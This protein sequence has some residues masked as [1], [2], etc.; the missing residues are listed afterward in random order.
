MSSTGDTKRIEKEVPRN[1]SVPT[2]Q[3]QD[4]VNQ[5]KLLEEIKNPAL[6]ISE[7]KSF[8]GQYAIASL[9]IGVV[10]GNLTQS[11]VKSL[12]EGAI[13]PGI[14]VILKL[15]FPNLEEISEWT[16]NVTDITF[17][18]GVIIKSLMEFLIILFI[19]YL[20]FKKILK[21]PELI[22]KKK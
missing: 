1:E 17:K 5:A 11:T 13:T 2:A 15:A 9:A 7:F 4:P 6:I 14:N 16:F 20:V 8:V 3:N 18:P 19:I 21:K 10:I 22:E 12:V